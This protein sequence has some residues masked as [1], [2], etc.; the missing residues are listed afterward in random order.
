MIIWETRPAW[1]LARGK[2]EINVSYGDDGGYL[3]SK[4]LGNWDFSK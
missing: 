1:C 4:N 2:L 3:A